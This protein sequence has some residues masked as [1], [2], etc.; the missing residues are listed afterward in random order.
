MNC[1]KSRSSSINCVRFWESSISIVFLAL[2]YFHPNS[3][4]SHSIH[5]NR[6]FF[7][8]ENMITVSKENVVK[9]YSCLRKV[10]ISLLMLQKNTTQECL[11]TINHNPYSSDRLETQCKGHKRKPTPSSQ[12]SVMGCADKPFYYQ[13]KATYVLFNDIE[14]S[15]CFTYCA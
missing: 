13:P 14:N 1:L 6:F 11:N 15:Y 2:T 3:N 9:A 5:R 8:L 7:F 10:L 4:T 12:S